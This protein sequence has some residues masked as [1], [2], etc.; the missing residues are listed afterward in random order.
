MFKARRP[1]ERLHRKAPRESGAVLME[2]F[3]VVIVL[4]L[5]LLAGYPLL[6]Q[7]LQGIQDSQ[8]T[9]F[10]SNTDYPTGLLQD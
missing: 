10:S 8:A 2:Y 6:I 3:M 4:A 9:E 7:Q 5:P 1:S